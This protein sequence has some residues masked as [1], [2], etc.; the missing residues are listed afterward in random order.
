MTTKIPVIYLEMADVAKFETASLFQLVEA[1]EQEIVTPKNIVRFNIQIQAEADSEI[2]RRLKKATD[3]ALLQV[4]EGKFPPSIKIK[5]TKEIRN[6][7]DQR[8]I[9]NSVKK[10]DEILAKK[11]K[12]S[13]AKQHQTATLL[14]GHRNESVFKIRYQWKNTGYMHTIYSRDYQ[15]EREYFYGQAINMVA[16]KVNQTKYLSDLFNV[17]SKIIKQGFKGFTYSLEMFN[18]YKKQHGDN[19]CFFAIYLNPIQKCSIDGTMGFFKG[20]HQ[21]PN[22]LPMEVFK[23]GQEINNSYKHSKR[24]SY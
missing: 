18:K 14:E 3:D 8:Y 19:L 9:E 13:L 7:E 4:I 17:G 11:G 6:R 2:N 5:C 22:Y 24:K 12:A 21:D 20:V 16:E 15:F 10:Q 23:Y 1:E